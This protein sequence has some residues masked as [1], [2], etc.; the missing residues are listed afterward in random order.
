MDDTD[1]EYDTVDVVQEG[2][3]PETNSSTNPSSSFYFTVGERLKATPLL[4][5]MPTVVHARRGITTTL[6]I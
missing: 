1:E 5:Y 2:G 3:Q 6:E 4:Q